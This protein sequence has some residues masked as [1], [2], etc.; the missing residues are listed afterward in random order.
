[1]LF[2]GFGTVA[3]LVR[4][5]R[6]GSLTR[7]WLWAVGAVAGIIFLPHVLWQIAHGWPTLEF[8]ANATQVKNVSYAPGA[9]MH[10]QLHAVGRADGAL[11]VAGPGLFLLVAREGR[12]YRLFAWAYMAIPQ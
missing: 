5:R 9:F 1:M 4:T 10:E 3:G 12:P 2:V 6:W 7:P 11:W 8:I